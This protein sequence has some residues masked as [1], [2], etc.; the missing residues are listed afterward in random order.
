MVFSEH[1]HG[2]LC[3][4]VH[5][6][7]GNTPHSKRTC[8]EKESLLVLW[9]MF[10]YDSTKPTI[11]LP[12]K[13]PNNRLAQRTQY[14]LH[15]LIFLFGT[16]ILVNPHGTVNLRMVGFFDCENVF[17][18]FTCYKEMNEGFYFEAMIC[19]GEEG[20][21]RVQ[22]WRWFLDE[23]KHV[24]YCTCWDFFLYARSIRVGRTVEAPHVW[25]HV[26]LNLWNP[27]FV[28]EFVSR[29]SF[30]EDHVWWRH[31]TRPLLVQAAS[32]PFLLRS[33]R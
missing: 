11:T 29:V 7:D 24:Q 32:S 4:M 8:S 12:I 25:W 30:R 2:I 28:S 13:I 3:W 27:S 16:I 19:K 18:T 23:G 9:T 1:L 5:L 15:Y 10:R 33:A 6:Q 26:W 20:T 31:V 17:I 14:I 22:P 21:V